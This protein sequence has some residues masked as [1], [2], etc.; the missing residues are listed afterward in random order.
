MQ[1]SDLPKLLRETHLTVEELLDEGTRLNAHQ[2]IR[3]IENA[4][5]LAE[6]DKL[7]VRIGRRLTPAAHG[8]LGYL[9]CSSPN[10]LSA[11]EAFQAFLPTRIS[12]VRLDRYIDHDHLIVRA[13]LDAKMNPEVSR[14]MAEICALTLLS[15]AEFIIGRPAHEVDTFFVH[16]DPGPAAGHADHIPGRVFFSS[17][18]LFVRV[19]M[20]LCEVANASAS[21]ES[22]ALVREQCEIM[23]ANLPEKSN[24]CWRKIEIMMISS[25]AGQ[26]TEDSA[27]AALFISKRTL[28]RRLKRE[29]TGFREIRDRILA[30]Q[31]G[32]YLKDRHLS[33]ESVATLLGYHDGAS[34]RRA[35][36]RWYGITPDQYRRAKGG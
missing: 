34:F 20:T 14:F 4:L 15:C 19:P 33:I 22:Y 30:R 5:R 10:L 16:K 3:V 36:K 26:L 12:F 24:T 6:D 13:I 23:L 1:A 31:A 18:E 29:G 11:I 21:N 32:N 9:A 2:Q 25:P 7:G 17:G 8:P 27:A 28:A 35:F